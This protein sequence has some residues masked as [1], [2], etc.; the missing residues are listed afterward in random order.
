MVRDYPYYRE[1]F[2]GRSMPFAFVDMDL[3]E[4]NAR[5]ILLRSGDK[6]IRVAS[7]S[8]RCVYLLKHILQSH[9]R[10]RGILCY[11][12]AEAVHL[13]RCGLD[14]LLI[15]YPAWDEKQ[16]AE[17]CRE[18]QQGKEIAVMADCR[19]HVE[20][21]EALG[22]AN[23]TIIPLCVDVDMSGDYLGL[24]FGVWRSR[25]SGP[26]AALKLC[27]DIGRRDFLS[28]RGIMGY[29]AQIAGVPDHSPAM[30]RFTRVAL[31][32]FKK[33]SAAQ[34]QKRREETVRLLTAYGHRLSI[35][36]GGGTGSLESTSREKGIT[37]VTAGSGFFAPRL[38][39][40]YRGFRH[41]PATGYAIEIVR[42]P[43]PDIFTCLGGGYAASGACGKD[44]LP[45]PY[46]PQGAA[47][48]DTEGAG[49]VQTPIFYRGN[50]RLDLGDPVFL[51]HA[52]A[53]ELCEHFNT[54]LLVSRGKITAEVPTY[55]GEGQCFLG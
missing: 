41:L 46:L 50:D 39:D 38:F 27:D 36:N 19:E 20:R 29:E 34:L 16:I 3:L 49:E 42:K 45:F 37:E 15:A 40:H 35:V 44:K 21:L 55:R 47:L 22:Q 13:S 54:L 17:V 23:R 28:L 7:K 8:V 48:I 43:R 10:F 24:H 2:R 1:I 12:A 18:L 14:D 32:F 5:S 51:R 30:G 6:K 53:G 25:I 9:E 52:K 33:L 26:A 11:T 4:E 31:R